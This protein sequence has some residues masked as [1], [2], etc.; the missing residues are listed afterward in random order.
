M[1]VVGLYTPLIYLVTILMSKRPAVAHH[2]AYVTGFKCELM[3]LEEDEREL[4]AILPILIVFVVIR[5]SMNIRKK[6]S[7]VLKIFHFT[8]KLLQKCTITVASI[9]ITD[10]LETHN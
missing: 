7:H 2:T 1:T 8:N 5:V 4:A 9:S 10:T 6:W 3:D